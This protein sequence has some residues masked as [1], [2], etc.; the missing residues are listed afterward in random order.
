M[1]KQLFL[2]VL[3]LLI[4]AGTKSTA[5]AEERKTYIPETPVL[6]SDVMTP[7]VL[8]SFGH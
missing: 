3:A 4:G 8:W 1:K 6:T 5:M 7:E 2:S